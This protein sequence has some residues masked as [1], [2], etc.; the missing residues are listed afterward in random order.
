MATLTRRLSVGMGSVLPEVV[1]QFTGDE[2]KDESHQRQQDIVRKD[3]A[4]EDDGAFVA[5]Q[6]D[7]RVL[8]G[9]VLD[10]VW[11]EKQEPRRARH[12]L[13]TGSS[14]RSE[15]HAN[16][17]ATARTWMKV[18]VAASALWWTRVRRSPSESAPTSSLLLPLVA[19]TSGRLAS[20]AAASAGALA[21]ALL[22]ARA[23]FRA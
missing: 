20:A 8:G 19:T 12:S 17:S 10:G 13:W 2:G 4:D 21:A 7:L 14:C 23:A 11:R 5:F 3:A 1:V 22:L 9:S 16:A 6:D 18:A 15:Q